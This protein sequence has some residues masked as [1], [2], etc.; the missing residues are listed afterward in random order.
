MVISVSWCV[1]VFC[2]ACVKPSSWY[3]CAWTCRICLVNDLDAAATFLKLLTCLS[4]WSQLPKTMKECE[5][6]N[7]CK[8]ICHI[9]GL[10]DPEFT[11][12]C[13][14]GS[15]L[16]RNALAVMAHFSSAALALR[17]STD[18][19]NWLQVWFDVDMRECDEA[20]LCQSLCKSHLGAVTHLMNLLFNC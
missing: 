17:S 13:R 14:G 4:Q 1:S 2:T 18:S 16:P 20:P 11:I 5:F 7:K 19:Q 6:L 8:P 12:P 15:K 3:Q 10:S 9:F